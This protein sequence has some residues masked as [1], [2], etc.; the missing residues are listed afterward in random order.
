MSTPNNTIPRVKVIRYYRRNIYG[1]EH[2]YVA[3][4]GDA[5]VLAQLTGRTT[6][7][8]GI[9]RELLRDLSGGRIQF[10]EIL[11]PKQPGF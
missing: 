2:E 9:I 10:Q 5:K 4:H 3:D 6:T 8:N 11:A 7:I 1:T